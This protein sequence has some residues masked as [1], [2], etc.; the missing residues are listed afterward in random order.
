MICE[1]PLLLFKENKKVV[2]FNSLLCLMLVFFFSSHPWNLEPLNFETTKDQNIYL[3]VRVIAQGL[4][5]TSY[6][7]ADVE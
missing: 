5:F 7:V 2:I 6:D 4:Y 3:L 1:Q